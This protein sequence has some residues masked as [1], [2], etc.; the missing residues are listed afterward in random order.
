MKHTMKLVG[1][2][3]TSI[4]LVACGGGGGNPP[5]KTEKVW[6]LVKEEHLDATYKE[7]VTFK[8][9][10]SGL[11]EKQLSRLKNI[12]YTYNDQGVLLKKERLDP[13]GKAHQYEEFDKYGEVT[14]RVERTNGFNGLLETTIAYE[15]KYPDDLNIDD[16]DVQKELQ[17]YTQRKILQ[18]YVSNELFPYIG[19]KLV[20]RERKVTVKRI[21]KFTFNGNEIITNVYELPGDGP[22][23]K[24]FHAYYDKY[25]IR[26]R[27]NYTYDYEED[28]NGNLKLRTNKNLN[29][30]VRYTWE[31][32]DVPVK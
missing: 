1:I 10:G 19:S 11:L 7:V 28:G 14:K 9:N 27:N 23:V 16:K 15:N 5:V 24:V 18:S 13:T 3:I 4:A 21:E 26:I 22:V 17:E 12:L 20:S 6:K 32:I 30:R 8:Y 2:V 29:E 31:Q 25:G